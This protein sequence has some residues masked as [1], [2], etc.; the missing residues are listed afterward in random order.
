MIDPWLREIDKLM[1]VAIRKQNQA[2]CSI[3]E[4]PLIK[5]IKK[6][7]LISNGEF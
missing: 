3:Y 1:Q 4:H 6:K 7:T 5:E 2:H